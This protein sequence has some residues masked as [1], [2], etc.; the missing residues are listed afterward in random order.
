MK[1]QKTSGQNS[2]VQKRTEFFFDKSRNGPVALLLP[3]QECFQLFGNDL[4]QHC[5]FRMACSV[6]KGSIQHAPAKAGFGPTE[7]TL[8][9]DLAG[10]TPRKS[11]LYATN[12]GAFSALLPIFT[13]SSQRF[14]LRQ[15]HLPGGASRAWIRKLIADL[16]EKTQNLPQRKSNARGS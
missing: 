13:G 11:E 10:R 3:R 15:H 1:P 9:Q 14:I 12:P 8:L 2:A 6:L 4:I 16:K 5:R 7:C